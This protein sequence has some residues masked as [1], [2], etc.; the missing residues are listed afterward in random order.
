MS[1][2]SETFIP[3]YTSTNGVIHALEKLNGFSYM[4]CNHACGR[5]VDRLINIIKIED[6]TCKNCK[7]NIEHG[8]LS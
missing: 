3:S 7:K 4:S 5:I 2:I 6:I 8:K 1:I